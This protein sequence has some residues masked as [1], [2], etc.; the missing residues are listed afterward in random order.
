M[1]VEQAYVILN[2]I[3]QPA[4]LNDLQEL[5]FCQ[6]WE[7]R[8]YQQIAQ[9]AD[10]QEEYIRYVGSQLWRLLSQALGEKVTKANVHSIVRRHLQQKEQGKVANLQSLISQRQDWG[11]AM[12]VS[13]FFGRAQELDTLQKWIVQDRCRLVTLLGMGGIGKTALAARV[14][15]Q[16]QEEFE[17][18]IW[19]SLRNAPPIEELLTDLLQFLPQQQPINLSETLDA[20]ILRLCKILRASRCLLIL[21]NYESVL[22][23]GN[24]RGCYREGYEGY[25]QLIRCFAQTPHQS[26]VVLTSQEKPSYISAKEGEKLPIRCLQVLGLSTDEAQKVFQAKGTFFG[27]EPEWKVLINY[28]GGNP[29]A[30]KIVATGIL[31]YFEG[32]ISPIIELLNSGRLIFD[33]IRQLL[34]RQ[35]NR[36]SNQEKQ[37]MY[38]LATHCE[39]ISYDELHN[40]F[41]SLLTD[42]QLLECLASLMKRSLIQKTT[43]GF[44]QK[45]VVMEYVMERLMLLRS[46]TPM[47]VATKEFDSPISLPSAYGDFQELPLCCPSLFSRACL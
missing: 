8:S 27:S 20:K 22:L 31:D 5:V 28:Y 34:E 32:R 9:Y 11:D 35:F 43:N 12:D 41:G 29:L 7:G 4:R 17:Y 19:R 6:S 23:A 18:L 47:K 24:I 13:V 36:L 1:T 44:T 16:I 42:H 26:T 10:Y 21:D 3:I 2:A 40:Y 45:P 30:L 37:V 15:Q 25:G 14:T 39:P 46:H 33:D 38:F